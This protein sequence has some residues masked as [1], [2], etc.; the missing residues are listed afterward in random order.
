[1][2]DAFADA[3][4]MKA[5]YKYQPKEQISAEAISPTPTG[6]SKSKDFTFTN[7]RLQTSAT[8][9]EID[10]AAAA[11]VASAMAA[12][13]G[14]GGDKKSQ[15]LASLLGGAKAAEQP[16]ATVASTPVAT[17]GA[18]EQ[19]AFTTENVAAGR[20]LFGS[21]GPL[22]SMAPKVVVVAGSN[23]RMMQE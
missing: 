23:R 15:L 4:R 16:P 9:G 2:A 22:L 8:G 7:I 10:T 14:T 1:M 12:S 11:N 5:A 18:R 20:R 21:Y 17:S 19:T 6:K 13:A 3:L